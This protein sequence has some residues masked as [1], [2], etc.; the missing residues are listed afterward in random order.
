[1]I[2]DQERLQEFIVAWQ[3]LTVS[4]V[5]TKF[6]ISTRDASALASSLRL[7]GVK[8]RDQRQTSTDIDFDALARVARVAEETGQ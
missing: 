6:D 7:S 1:M 5:A 3:T 8:L 4:E 2:K